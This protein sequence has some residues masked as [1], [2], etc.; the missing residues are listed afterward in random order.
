MIDG[1][2]YCNMTLEEN[3]NIFRKEKKNK[4]YPVKGPIVLTIYNTVTGEG[5]SGYWRRGKVPNWGEKGVWMPP[6]S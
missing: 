4:T 1:T 5:S 3:F 6:V 2:T